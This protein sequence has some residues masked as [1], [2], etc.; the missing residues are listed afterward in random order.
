MILKS[1]FNRPSGIL[2]CVSNCPVTLFQHKLSLSFLYKVKTF[3]M[4]RF[5]SLFF[6]KFFLWEWEKLKSK[7][8]KLLIKC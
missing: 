1:A 7:F 3:K 6:L 2:V 4:Q 5:T 8:Y